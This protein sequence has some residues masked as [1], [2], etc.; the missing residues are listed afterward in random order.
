MRR[1]SARTGPVVWAL[2]AV[3]SAGIMSM[4]G[5]RGLRADA[6]GHQP[7]ASDRAPDPKVRELL[8]DRLATART[9]HEELTRMFGLGLATSEDLHRAHLAVLRAELDLCESDRD[10]IAALKKVVAAARAYEAQT[11]T[12]V[13]ATL[14]PALARAR[15]KLTRIDA[16]IELRQAEA[17]TAEPWK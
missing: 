13:D 16:E 2:A 14:A 10:R 11:A 6:A 17:G 7:A 4:T 3:V 1:S 15:A 5:Q 12:G 9:I 8:A